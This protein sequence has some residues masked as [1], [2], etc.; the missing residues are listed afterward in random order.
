MTQKLLSFLF[1]GVLLAIGYHLAAGLI[2]GHFFP[3]SRLF[4]TFWYVPFIAVPALLLAVLG[5]ALGFFRSAGWGDAAAL[6]LLA[7]ITA[8]TLEAPCSRGMGCL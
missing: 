8:L 6:G 2:Y 3:G 5:F 4:I 1:L 7:A